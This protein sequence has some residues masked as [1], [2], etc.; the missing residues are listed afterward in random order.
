MLSI[1]PNNLYIVIKN[2]GGLH[3]HLQ[4]QGDSL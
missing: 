2:L 1:F 3:I 4:E